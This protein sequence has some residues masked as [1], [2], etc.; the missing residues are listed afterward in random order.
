VP[1]TPFHFGPGLLAKGIA[2]RWCSWTAF[3]ASNVLIDVESFYYLM[4]GAWPVHRRLHTFVGAAI[5]GIATAGLLLGAR[6]VMPRIRRRLET[7][8]PTIRAEATLL[9]IVV[10]AMLGALSHPL[11]DGIMH[12]DIEP[13]R[14]WRS[15]NPLHELIGLGNLHLACIASAL[16][17]LVLVYVWRW[18]E[19][20]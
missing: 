13:L 4:Q 9:G 20:R 14:P 10:G 18:R 6:A 2:A 16:A 1:F 12:A 7:S 8:R 5:V 3:V 15:G 19:D 17:G 11:L